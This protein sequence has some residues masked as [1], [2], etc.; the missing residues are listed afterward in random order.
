MSDIMF[1]E[2]PVIGNEYSKG[3]WQKIAVH[4][5]NSIKGFFGP[6][7]FLS[8]FYD[9]PV[10]YEGLLYR[11]T[12]CAYQAAKLLPHYRP[13]LQNVSSATSKKTWKSF[14]EDSLYDNCPDEWDGR[15]YDVM[16]SVVFDKFLRNKVLRQK[17]LDTGDRY[18]E[19]TNLWRDVVWGVDHKLGGTNWLGRILMN[20]RTYWRNT[21]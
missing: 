20:T 18:L 16:S 15:K 2:V 21:L 5:E 19:E 14:G 12:E 17:L 13:L 1:N 9:S 10:Y 8:N 3:D 4:D 7:V 6:W 11:S